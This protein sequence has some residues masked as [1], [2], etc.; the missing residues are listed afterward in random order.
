MEGDGGVTVGFGVGVAV[1]VG[2]VVAVGVG[3]GVA[4]GVPDGAGV[5]AVLETEKRKAA[6]FPMFPAAS[7][8]FATITCGPFASV[9][10]SRGTDHT[11]DCTVALPSRFVPSQKETAV[12]PTLSV[13][14]AFREMEPEAVAPATGAVM[15]TTGLDVSVAADV[16]LP[17]ARTANGTMRRAARIAIPRARTLDRFTAVPRPPRQ[18]CL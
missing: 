16:A 6:L 17:G 3:F 14:V 7:R 11:P 18:G 4:V 10:V 8:P 5:D 2:L 15:T 13:A 12:V 9:R 1:A